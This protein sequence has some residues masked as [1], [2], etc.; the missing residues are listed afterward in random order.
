MG[1]HRLRNRQSEGS[2]WVNM[3]PTEL[4]T[5]RERIGARF[6]RRFC[7]VSTAA[8]NRSNS[9]SV[10]S[11]IPF[12]RSFGSKYCGDEIAVGN[13]LFDGACRGGLAIGEGASLS[14]AEEK[15]SAPSGR[16]RPLTMRQ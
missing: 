5:E 8:S 16:V 12:D 10:S 7:S 13:S 9:C 3:R 6:P 15:R 11:F 2:L 1:S 14:D 4:A